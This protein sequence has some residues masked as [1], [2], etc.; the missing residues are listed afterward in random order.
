MQSG[1][2]VGCRFYPLEHPADGCDQ[3]CLSGEHLPPGTIP[4]VEILEMPYASPD[5]AHN[6]F[7]RIAEAGTNYQQDQIAAG[8]IGLCYQTTVWDKDNG[9]DWA[10][11]FSK[12]SAVIVIKSVVTDPALNVVEIAQAIY[13]KI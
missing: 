10:C 5:A 11:T 3:T 1:K 6:A 13:P 4:A 8:N 7:V 2:V 9:T 12:G